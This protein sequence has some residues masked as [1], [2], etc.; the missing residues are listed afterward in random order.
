MRKW[1]VFALLL[2]FCFSMMVP[3]YAAEDDFVPSITYKPM[4]DAGSGWADDGCRLIGYAYDADGEETAQVHDD[5]NRIYVTCNHEEDHIHGGPVGEDHECLVITPL[6][7]AET[8]AKIPEEA[9]KELLKVYE[10]LLANQM[11]LMGECE[12]LD[13]LVAEALGEGKTSDDLVVRDLFDVTVL[14]DELKDYLKQEGTTICLDL[15]LGLKPGDFVQVVAY[16]DGKWQ[17]IEKVEIAADGSYTCTT[18]KKI[19]P[20]A[21]LVPAT[22]VKDHYTPAPDTGDAIADQLGLWVAV[23]GCS[24]AAIVILVVLQR[25]R[26]AEN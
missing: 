6:S 11:K 24:L 19:C 16:V 25:K 2:V 8:S 3:T 12:G 21:V 13:E 18:Y 20:V 5:G 14:C 1:I 26:K 15:D 23:A 10:D 4:P 17:L 7:E 22:T 9:R